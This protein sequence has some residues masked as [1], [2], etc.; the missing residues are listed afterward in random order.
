MKICQKIGAGILLTGLIIGAS[1]VAMAERASRSLA[2]A[3]VAVGTAAFAVYMAETAMRMFTIVDVTS[4][5]THAIVAFEQDFSN[6]KTQL[7]TDTKDQIQNFLVG[8]SKKSGGS[9]LTRSQGPKLSDVKMNVDNMTNLVGEGV[10]DANMAKEIGEKTTYELA[11][12]QQDTY[13]SAAGS[14][15]D[16]IEY[17]EV[18]TYAEQEQ[19]IKT[20]AQAMVL[21]KNLSEKIPAIVDDMNAQYNAAIGTNENEILRQYAVQCLAYDQMLSLEQQ[22]LG[23]R[24]KA[25]GSAYERKLTPI[26]DKLEVK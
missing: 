24:L 10:A 8:D 16:K 13:T 3:D 14:L 7:E 12:E 9:A 22:V 19:I 26:R 6:F 1:P 17:Q 15:A 4:I 20:L 11:S 21:R 25:R 5:P 23:L 18:R 2:A